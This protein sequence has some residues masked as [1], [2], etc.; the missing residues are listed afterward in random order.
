MVAYY[1]FVFFWWLNFALSHFGL[2]YLC[3]EIYNYVW[4]V[5][6]DS[7]YLGAVALR[8]IDEFRMEIL[9]ASFFVIYFFSY[10]CDIGLKYGNFFLNGVTFC[11]VA[12]R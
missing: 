10:F 8:C 3:V 12:K 5:C 9:F 6:M 4:S 2:V 1:G 7:G 11:G